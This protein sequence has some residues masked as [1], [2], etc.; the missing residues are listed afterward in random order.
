MS[1]HLATLK[2]PRF[3]NCIV[4]YP[5]KDSPIFRCHRKKAEWYLR[6]NLAVKVSDSPLVILLTFKPNGLAHADDKFFL[7]P[8]KNICVVCGKTTELTKHHIVPYYFS[9]HID[10]Y[11]SISTHDIVLLCEEHHIQAEEYSIKARQELLK[12][13]SISTKPE[14]EYSLALNYAGRLIHTLLHHAD[15]IPKQ[16]ILYM[17]NKLQEILDI[18]QYDEHTLRTALE[19]LNRKIKVQSPG[20]GKQLMDK[21]DDIHA[22]IVYWRT[23]FIE[24]MHPQFLPKYWDVN[25]V[26]R[27]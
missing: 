13:Y 27:E 12:S 5:D 15:K 11:R 18:N 22:F 17:H 4:C 7:E 24:T 25:K 1:F 26:I 14:S 9:K 16:R 3:S 21:I 6:R 2:S 10:N 23:L 8:K 20:F 19:N